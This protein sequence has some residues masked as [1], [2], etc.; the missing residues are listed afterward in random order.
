MSILLGF[1]ALAYVVNIIVGYNYMFLMYH[2]NTPYSIFYNLVGGSPVLYPIV[3]VLLF[4]IYVLVFYYAAQFIRKLRV[5][6]NG[7]STAA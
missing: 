2:D 6:K 1:S 3:V 7:A 5:K 4:V